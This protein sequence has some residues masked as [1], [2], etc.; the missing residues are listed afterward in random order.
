M[1]SGD[2]ELDSELH[3]I[4]LGETRNGWLSAPLSAAELEELLGPRWAPVLRFGL[5][6]N[7]SIRPIDDFPAWGGRAA[8][9]RPARKSTWAA[10]AK[11][12]G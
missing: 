5:R 2:S 10:S 9:S 7:G 1:G 11:L 8:S 4:T 6:Q 3:R 12:L